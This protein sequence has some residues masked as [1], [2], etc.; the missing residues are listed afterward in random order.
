MR[1][2]Y[3]P[4]RVVVLLLFL[5]SPSLP[6]AAQGDSPR[7]AF[8]AAAVVVSGIEPGARLALV[9][10]GLATGGLLPG[11]IRFSELLV[12]DA[13][14]EA[15]L[16]S[17]HDVPTWSVWAAVDVASGEVTVAAPEGGELRRREVPPRALRA[18]LDGLDDPRRF[19]EV[20]VV[21]PPATPD[22][23]MSGAWV[24]SFGDGGEGDG[25]GATDGNVR[26]V[27]TLLEPLGDSPAA[28]ERFAPGDV[29]VAIDPDSLEVWTASVPGR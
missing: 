13:L 29:I 10:V 2:R 28:A 11:R 16:T 19:L 14:G 27:P 18:E 1:R 5:L 7:V 21:R 22:D 23:G 12:A 8:E 15:R 24:R 25:D 9:G 26:V 3:S 17:E 4:L 20:L 6:A